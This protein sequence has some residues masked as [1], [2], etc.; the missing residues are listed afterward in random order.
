MSRAR[1][2]HRAEHA[3]DDVMSRTVTEPS[4]GACSTIHEWSGAER[5][6]GDDQEAVE[7][8]ARDREVAF[9]APVNSASS[10]VTEPTFRSTS[11]TH[12]LEEAARTR[13]A[14]FDLAKPIR[15]TGAVSRVAK[16][17]V[18]IAVDSFRPP[19]RAGAEF[20]RGVSVAPYQ[21]TPF[22]SGLFAHQA[23]SSRWRR[24]QT[25]S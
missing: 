1:G 25:T 13:A 24:T 19:I 3:I 10:Y 9:D 17:S 5:R 21:L 7:G 2:P 14:H 4:S 11:R 22:P 16:C 20:M 6:A 23:S 15:R 12:P 18:T 8:E